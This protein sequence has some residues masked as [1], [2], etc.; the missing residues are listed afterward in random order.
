MK[1]K[2][3]YKLQF[4]DL[5]F[6]FWWDWAFALTYEI[7]DYFDNRPVVNISLVFFVL[8][9]H[10]PIRNSWT[11]ECDPPKWGIEIHHNALWIYKGGKG[12]MNGGNK[13]WI[14]YFPWVLEWYRRSLRLKTDTPEQSFSL[15][16]PW[17]HETRG[18]HKDF[19][20][21]EWINVRWQET[22]PYSY[23]LKSGDVQHVNATIHVVQLEWRIKAM[24]W[25]PLI[26]KVITYIEVEFDGVVG[27]RT[28]SWKGGCIGCYY[29]M[30]PGESP[31]D[32]LK[33][34]EMNRKFN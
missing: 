5:E 31:V 8:K 23:T 15:M 27:E 30:L 1:D 4:Y 2:K 20:K 32:T 33:R 14:W 16:G 26:K 11:D 9:I 19:W 18:H 3:I 17:E 6:V 28:R 22:H 7:C 12:N 10:M 29:A 21:D 13:W 34:M 24:M 25:C